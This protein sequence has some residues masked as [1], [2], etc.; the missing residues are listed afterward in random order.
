MKKKLFYT[1]TLKGYFPTVCYDVMTR[2]KYS[3]LRF[4]GSRMEFIAT[5][6][7]YK[8]IIRKL[9]SNEMYCKVIGIDSR[10]LT[11]EEV[12]IDTFIQSEPDE[13]IAA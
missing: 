1:I 11:P 3:D 10:E 12:A 7:D 4:S 9:H 13:Q 2:R 6:E 5:E 8:V